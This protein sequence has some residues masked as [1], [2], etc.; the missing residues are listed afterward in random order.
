MLYENDGCL[1]VS[2]LRKPLSSASLNDKY[3]SFGIAE[4]SGLRKPL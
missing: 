3:S 2:G 4:R 1:I